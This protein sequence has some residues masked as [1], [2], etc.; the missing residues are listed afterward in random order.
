MNEELNNLIISLSSKLGTSAE[1]L[2]SVLLKQTQIEAIESCFYL[3]F[4]NCIIYIAYSWIKKIALKIKNKEDCVIDEY[5]LPTIWF[6][7]W[8]WLFLGVIF[9]LILLTNVVTFLINPEYL[10][11]KQII[12]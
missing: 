11:L 9:N 1:H 7:F 3:V 2:W 6:I 5:T 12:K 10:A 8:I 4:V